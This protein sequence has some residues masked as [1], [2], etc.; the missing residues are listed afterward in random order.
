MCYLKDKRNNQERFK[1]NK[2]STLKK[3]KPKSLVLAFRL[4]IIIHLNYAFK[5]AHRYHQNQV[6]HSSNFQK[7]GLH[8]ADF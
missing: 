8:L 3:E 6:Y 5:K 2:T 4:F 1:R 7:L